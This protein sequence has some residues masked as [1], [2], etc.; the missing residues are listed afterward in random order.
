M[1]KKIP[2]FVT[3]EGFYQYKVMSFG[4]KNS[5]ATF[6]RLINRIFENL[7]GCETYIDDIVELGS[8]W[9]QHLQRVRELFC[10]PRVANLIV[11]LV[12]SEFGHA[13]VTYLGHVVGQGQVKPVN[14]KVE[15]IIKYPT[16]TTRKELMSFLGMVGYYRKFCRNFCQHL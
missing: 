13:H 8:T 7:E 14:A 5:P 16:P 1:A 9:E 10:Q 2:T 11:N 15:V 6:Q 4:M 12:K 3:P